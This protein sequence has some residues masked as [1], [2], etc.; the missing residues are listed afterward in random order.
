MSRE[1]I[2][3][4][5]MARPCIR[6]LK[7]YASAKDEFKDFDQEMIYL[8]ANENPYDNG[9][10]RYPDPHQLELKQKISEIK[11]VAVANILLGNGSDEILDMIFRVFFEPGKDNIII[12]TPTFGMFKVLSNVNNVHFKEVSLTPD[13]QLDVPAIKNAVDQDTKAVFI[14]SPNNPTGNLMDEGAIRALLELGILVIIDEAYIDFSGAQSW[15]RQLNNYNNLIVTQTF[16][17][18][19]GLAGIR[20]GACYADTK[21]IEL[22]KKVKM[23]YN[24]NVLTQQTALKYLENDKVTEQEIIEIIS[25]RNKLSIELQTIGFVQKIYH[26]DSN[27]ILVKV[28]DADRRYKELLDKDLVIRNRTKEPLCENCLRITVGTPKENKILLKRLQYLD[29]KNNENS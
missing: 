5:K 3:I 6:D 23:P 24:V 18:A 15:N 21:I 27:F 9:L 14:C 7:P 12:N 19:Y 4:R 22:L 25:S 2:N 20:L 17:K 8:D 26:S 28:D 29:A 16:S 11:E 10:N 1:K 13:F